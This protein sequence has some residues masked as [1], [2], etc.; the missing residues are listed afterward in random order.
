VRRLAAATVFVASIPGIGKVYSLD[1]VRHLPPSCAVTHASLRVTLA[2][3]YAPPACSGLVRRG[4]S[5]RRPRIDARRAACILR[6]A[7]GGIAEVDG[8]RDA[9]RRFCARL[10]RTPGWVNDPPAVRS[11]RAGRPLP[12]T[13]EVPSS[14]ME[15]TLRCARPAAGCSARVAD[16]VVIALVR[17]SR[18]TRGDIV[19]FETPRL[20]LLRCGAGGRFLK[21]IIGLP[22]E[23]VSE[24]GGYLFVDGKRLR[25]PYLAAGRRDH[26]PPRRWRVPRGEYFVVGDNRTAS[27]DSRVWG[28][29]RAANIVGREAAVLRFR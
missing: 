9:A 24:R 27:C 29:V 3:S 28:T 23:T 1:P 15:P 10:A 4:W 11:K 21:R 19:L 2:G 17:P 5:Q 6:L 25:E 16:L 26:L 7:S 12:V 14:S 22:G 20:A 8:P 18:L 13:V